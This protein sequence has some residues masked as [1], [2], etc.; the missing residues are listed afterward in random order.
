[1]KFKRLIVA[2]EGWGHGLCVSDTGIA[3]ELFIPIPYQYTKLG[4]SLKKIAGCHRRRFSASDNL[5]R[6]LR[7]RAQQRNREGEAKRLGS[8]HVDDQLNLGG[9]LYWQ[10]G[11]L[12]ALEDTAGIDAGRPVRICRAAAATHQAACRSKLAVLIDREYSV[13]KRKFSKLVTARIE[14]RIGANHKSTDF[15]LA[16]RC[17][18]RIEVAFGAGLQNMRWPL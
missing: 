18:A 15:Q 4:K 13:P 8:F 12:G 11:G 7:P 16:Q 9:L 14:E 6:W 3:A 2:Q 1:M 17:K 10:I 5:T